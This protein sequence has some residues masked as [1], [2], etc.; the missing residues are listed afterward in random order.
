MAPLVLIFP[1]GHI[2]LYWHLHPESCYCLKFFFQVV[3]LESVSDQAY[4]Q[5]TEC[6][7]CESYHALAE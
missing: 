7:E 1:T 2:I 6:L 4:I 5:I 3:L